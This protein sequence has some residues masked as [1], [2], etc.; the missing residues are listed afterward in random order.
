MCDTL[1]KIKRKENNDM[2]Q[3]YS[4][5]FLFEKWIEGWYR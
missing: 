3:M 5:K 2:I 4:F 1:F